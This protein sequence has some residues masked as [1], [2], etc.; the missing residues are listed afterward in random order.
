MV[1]GLKV[2][3]LMMAMSG[4]DIS[5]DDTAQGRMAGTGCLKGCQRR[6]PVLCF[7]GN[8]YLGE[9]MSTRR[10]GGGRARSNPAGA[11]CAGLKI[12]CSRA[13]WVRIPP[14]AP[15]IAHTQCS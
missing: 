6:N 1:I 15:S 3:D 14:P 12:P 8:D 13:A 9:E 5:L 4:I 7:G 11:I 2:N 10:R